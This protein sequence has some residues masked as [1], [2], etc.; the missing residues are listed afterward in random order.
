MDRSW[1]FIA[2]EL[3]FGPFL[4]LAAVA[5]ILFLMLLQRPSQARQLRWLWGLW[6]VLLIGSSH[7]FYQAFAYPLKLL[8]PDSVKV[9]ADAIVVASAGVHESGAP[10]PGSTLRAYAAGRLYL[11]GWAPKV[12]IAGGVTEPYQP[13]VETKGMHIILKGMGV[14]EEAIIIEDRSVD[15]YQNGIETVRILREHEAQR[16]LLVSH[17]YHLYRLSAVFQKLGVTTY[18]YAAN[19]GY[20]RRPDPWWTFFDWENYA[21]LRTVAHEYLGLIG[22]RLFGRI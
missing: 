3:A 12:I 1:R 13:P 8:T 9:E 14:P 6:A 11:E 22:Y 5:L 17:D 2:E 19:L 15:S 20:P 18:P 16:I 10:T 4:F 7:V 21:R